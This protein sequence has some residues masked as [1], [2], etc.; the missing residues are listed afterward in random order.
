MNDKI[1]INAIFESIQGEG[2][3]AGTPML[4]IRT[5]GCTRACP[6]C[7]TK[8]HI[9]GKEMNIDDIVKIIKKSK[10]DY[11][12]W[13][14]GEPLLWVQQICQIRQKVK[15]K[16][17]HLETNGDLLRHSYYLETNLGKEH[18]IDGWF[19][20]IACSPK[21]RKTA[22]KVKETLSFFN[23]QYYDIKIV[24]DLKKVGVDMLKYATILMPLTIYNKKK[25][26]EVQKKVWNYCVKNNLKFTPRLQVFIWGKKRKI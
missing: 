24:T 21:D 2:R 4:F 15:N 6:W 16:N 26:L 18:Y 25:D 20:Y 22:K 5:S 8:Y 19:N 7:D 13:T 1:K 17:F 12:C 11:V 10:L 14:G 3:W 23:K 9:K